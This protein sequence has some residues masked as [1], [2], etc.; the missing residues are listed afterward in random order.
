MSLETKVGRAVLDLLEVT[1]SRLAADLLLARSEGRI[2]IGGDN[3]LNN[4]MTTVNASLDITF[5]SG[6]SQVLRTVREN[7]TPAKPKRKTTR[8][9]KS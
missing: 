1:K 8:K 6:V 2:I 9:S 3:E 5:D 4:L 7:E